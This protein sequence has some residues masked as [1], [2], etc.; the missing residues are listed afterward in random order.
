M[1]WLNALIPSVDANLILHQL[2]AQASFAAEDHDPRTMDQLRADGLRDGFL[3]GFPFFP[4][5]APSRPGA[6]PGW[7]AETEYPTDGTRPHPAWRHSRPVISVTVPVLTLLGHSDEPAIM[8]GVGP[9]PLDLARTLAGA[10]TSWNRILVHPVTG[11]T[12]RY[13]RTTYRVPSDLKRFLEHRDRTCRFP[14]CDR[15]ARTCDIDHLRPWAD[16]GG[17]NATTLA[18]E[19]RTHHRLRHH[20][21][22]KP[23]PP[24]DAGYDP[25]YDDDAY[26]HRAYDPVPVEWTSPTG[27]TH[28][29]APHDGD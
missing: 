5:H 12:L 22:W 19:C 24:D 7:N 16:G 15:P 6:R 17:T 1:S 11:A 2:T 14:E 13:D 28:T 10:A 23:E 25:E 9:I 18:H 20:T 3:A 4:A 21:P 29:S 26:D 27:H 8:D